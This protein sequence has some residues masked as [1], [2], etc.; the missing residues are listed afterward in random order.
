MFKSFPVRPLLPAVAAFAV[1]LTFPDSFASSATNVF[2][3]SREASAVKHLEEPTG[4]FEVSPIDSERTLSSDIEQ[5][6]FSSLTPVDFVS[7][8]G[9]VRLLDFSCGNNSTISCRLTDFTDEENTVLSFYADGDLIDKCTL[10]FAEDSDGVFY[11]S[12]VSSDTAKRAAGKTLNY[13]LVSEDEQNSASG[14][15]RVSPQKAIIA[16]GRIYGTLEWTDEQ[17]GTHP[18]IGAKVKADV[19]KGEWSDETYTDCNGNYRMDYQEIRLAP[20]GVPIVH[21]YSESD[22]VKVF[23]G[24][25]Y[26]K[27]YEFGSGAGGEFSY[28]FSPTLDGDM[29]KAMMVFQGAKNFSD[30]AKELNDGVPIE[31]CN[32][33]YPY[34]KSQRSFYDGEGTVHIGQRTPKD[35]EF[36]EIY[37]CWDLI[38][39]EYGHHVQEVF[40][41]T[42]NPGGLHFIP[43]NNIDDQLFG[44][45]SLPEAKERG[46]KLSWGEGWPTYWSTVAQ[47]H[48]SDDLKSIYTV[49]DTKYTATNS[50]NYELDFYGD[51]NGDADEQA[52]Q[53]FLYKIYDSKTDDFDRFA[54][55]E[56]TLWNIVIQYKP[57]TFSEFI[58]DLYEEGYDKF[59]LARLLDQ[60]HV[61]AG[62]ITVENSASTGGKP[63]F[64][65][66]TESGSRNLK[67]D[68]FD[69]YFTTPDDLIIQKVLNISASGDTVSY[70]PST[71]VWDKIKKSPGNKFNAYFVARQTL[72]YVS[73]NYYSELSSFSKPSNIFIGAIQLESSK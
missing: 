11:S 69:L 52:I 8:E 12:A 17:G 2:R 60:Y 39:H 10:Y 43:G 4:N 1:F 24:G 68:Q 49:G 42:A 9:K 31:F 58:Q 34:G 38:G 66:S 73:G 37:A 18:L 41:I 72:S 33:E 44:G 14:A 64:T 51:G 29:G 36:P 28:T 26:E 5:F 21:I 15:E 45:Y 46:Q 32:F 67:F 7:S 6:S 56:T 55:G 53:R 71:I 27:T 59:D 13:N 30:Y 20:G 57:V 47:S 25:T 61:I 22:N 63:T 65:W 16:S 48:F 40:G 70:T 62:K 23:N 3:G 19:S 35:S 54:L 50:L